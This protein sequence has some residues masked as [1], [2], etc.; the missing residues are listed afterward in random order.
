MVTFASLAILQ[1]RPSGGLILLGQI[2]LIIAIF[3]FLLILPQKKERERHQAM[4]D[5]LKKG[6]QVVTSGGIIATV[7]FAEKD[8]ITV[9]TAENTRLIVQRPS[10]S[11]VVAEPKAAEKE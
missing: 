5:A 9:K 2:F 3:Y 1:N 8:Q 4:I 7:I 6:D 11:S 10:I